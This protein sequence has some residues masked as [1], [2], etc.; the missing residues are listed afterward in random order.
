[1]GAGLD[2]FKINYDVKI[3]LTFITFLLAS[4]TNDD[5]LNFSS[6]STG[7]VLIVNHKS[8]EILFQADDFKCLTI[9]REGTKEYAITIKTGEAIFDT[10]ACNIYI[11]GM[12]VWECYGLSSPRNLVKLGGFSPDGDEVLLE[13]LIESGEVNIVEIDNRDDFSEETVDNE[14][15]QLFGEN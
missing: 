2:S 10:N 11:N 4:C 5:D 14:L 15:W 12:L 1:M 7:G 3:I 8:K 13:T 9:N 6:A